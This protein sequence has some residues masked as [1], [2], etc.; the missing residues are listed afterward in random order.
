MRSIAARFTDTFSLRVL[1]VL[2][3]VAGVLAMQAGRGTL[4]YF[5]AAAASTGNT[6]TTGTLSATVTQPNALT[7]SST[8]GGGMAATALCAKTVGTAL[9]TDQG[10][11]PG[12][13]CVAPVAVQNSGTVDA[14]LRMRIIRTAGAAAVSAAQSFNDRL[15]LTVA[16]VTTGTCTVAGFAPT[17][18]AYPVAYAGFDYVKNS[19]STEIRNWAFSSLTANSAAYD[20]TTTTTDPAAGSYYNLLGD[21]TISNEAGAN[22]VT[23]IAD[24]ATRNFCVAML[25]P[26][27]SAPATNTAGDN[28]AQGATN[29]YALQAALAQRSSR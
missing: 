11:T 20:P 28:A 17:A 7:W 13:Y 15:Q 27:G 14:F 6:F 10:F 24:G 26:I 16:E 12:V 5:T 9:I 19:G 2:A 21:D 22:T 18:E 4:A 8:A 23:D 1:L 25:F 3:M 29:T